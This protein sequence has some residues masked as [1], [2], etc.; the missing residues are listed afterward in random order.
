M[1]FDPDSYADGSVDRAPTLRQA[2]AALFTTLL[3]IG[4]LWAA[5]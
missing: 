1:T 2:A 3:L 4:G 5:C